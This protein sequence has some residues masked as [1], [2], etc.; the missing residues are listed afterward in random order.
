MNDVRLI[1]AGHHKDLLHGAAVRHIGGSAAA[2]GQ[3]QIVSGV[4]SA[5]GAVKLYALG[6]RLA[7]PLGIH[8]GGGLVA[9]GGQGQDHQH[10]QQQGHKTFHRI[11]PYHS[12]KTVLPAG[13]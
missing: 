3:F 5:H 6:Q 1:L 4:D 10:G 11:A 7:Q 12:L 9:A 8:R 13:I 2:L